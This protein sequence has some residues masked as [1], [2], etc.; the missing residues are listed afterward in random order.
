MKTN[1]FIYVMKGREGRI[2]LG[3]SVDPVRRAYDVGETVEIAYV[4]PRIEEAERVERRAHRILALTHKHV[5][6][7]WFIAPVEAAKQ[8]I[9]IAQRQV[10]AIEL[11]LAGKL[12]N[13]KE[14]M[15]PIPVRL[16]RSTVQLIDEEKAKSGGAITQ[17]ATMIRLLVGEALRAR[18]E[19]KRK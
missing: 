15:T 10:D 18:L 11:P 4:S 9:E 5:R 12:G 8:A 1:A 2:K 19:G 16:P 7:D 17:R 3:H 6:G 14:R 13:G